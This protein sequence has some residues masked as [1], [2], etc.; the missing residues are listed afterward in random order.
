M[1]AIEDL[2]D[3]LRHSPLLPQIVELLANQI[4]AER[5]QR[6]TF[7]AEMTPE[8][9]VEFIALRADAQSIQNDLVGEVREN[10]LAA[11]MSRRVWIDR[12]DRDVT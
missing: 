4:S 2:I 10:M 7:Y 5:Q 8:Q 9:K 3:P 6:S 12:H 1:T 11:R